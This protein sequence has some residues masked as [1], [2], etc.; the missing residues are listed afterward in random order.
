MSG[1]RGSEMAARRCAW[2]DHLHELLHERGAFGLWDPLFDD[3]LAAGM[4][5]RKAYPVAR[6]RVELAIY[7]LHGL[8]QAEAARRLSV[9]LRTVKYDARA[10]RGAIWLA[11]LDGPTGRVPLTPEEVPID[12]RRR[13][14]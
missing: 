12:R 2:L 4:H 7:L 10:I 11:R 8:E 14:R 1:G 5:W 3:L 9:S 6:R 13:R